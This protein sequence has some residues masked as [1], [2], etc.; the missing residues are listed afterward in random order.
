MGYRT[1]KVDQPEE[2]LDTLSNL[3]G[4]PLR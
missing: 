1:V 3:L 4:F 2:A